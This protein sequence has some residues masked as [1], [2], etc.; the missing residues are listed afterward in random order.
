MWLLSASELLKAKYLKRWRGPKGNWQYAYPRDSSGRI[1][2]NPEVTGAGRGTLRGLTEKDVK[3]LLQRYSRRPKG[4]G[5]EKTINTKQELDV[6]LTKSTFALMSAGRNPNNPEDM[7]LTDDQVKAR[8]RAMLD[9][10]RAEG[11]VFTQCRGKYE[12]PEESVMVMTHDADRDN[13]LGLGAKYNQDSVVFCSKGS[14][15]MVYTT[16]PKKGTETMRGSGYEEVPGAKNYYTDMPLGVGGK[17]RFTMSLADVEKALRSMGV[18]MGK[19]IL[20]RPTELLK[21]KRAAIGATSEDGKRKKVA[22]GKWVPVKKGRKVAKKTTTKSNAKSKTSAKKTPVESSANAFYDKA[23]KG[24]VTSK[25]FKKF[26]TVDWNKEHRMMGHIFARRQV[27]FADHRLSPFMSDPKLKAIANAVMPFESD[28]WHVLSNL[29]DK[30]IKILAV[31]LNRVRMGTYTP[32]ALASYVNHNSGMLNIGPLADLQQ[33]LECGAYVQGDHSITE[34]KK[35]GYTMFGFDDKEA[36][37]RVEQGFKRSLEKYE[38][39]ARKVWR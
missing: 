13:V 39:L 17:V 27:L 34:H 31:T 11:Y 22:E 35:K 9:D 4:E 7:K 29:T 16:G 26:N 1:P 24:P 14:N 10:L 3:K 18:T 21:A 37:K 25:L 12:N 8:H 36:T 23:T 5:K 19:S 32:A 33:I 38:T 15:E 28:D 20:F 6:L 2:A 30:D